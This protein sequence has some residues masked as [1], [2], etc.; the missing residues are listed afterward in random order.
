MI[1]AQ[2]ELNQVIMDVAVRMTMRCSV[3]RS[4]A[5]YYQ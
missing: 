2:A 1:A 5:A 4:S 3:Y